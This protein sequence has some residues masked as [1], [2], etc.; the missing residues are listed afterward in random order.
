MNTDRHITLSQYAEL[1]KFCEASYEQFREALKDDN[2]CRLLHGAIGAATEAGE[3]LEGV[4]KHLFY[5][6]PLDILNIIEEDGDI[7]WYL[8]RIRESIGIQCAELEVLERNILKLRA[9]YGQAFDAA[10]AINRNLSAERLAL[11]G[12][13]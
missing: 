11:G 13:K 4:K 5:G 2:K 10:K 1:S 12:A 9:R 3:L 8:A 6:K 7:N